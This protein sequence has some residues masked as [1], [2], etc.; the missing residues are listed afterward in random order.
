MNGKFG[1]LFLTVDHNGHLN[2]WDSSA[3]AMSKR[4]PDEI[5]LELSLTTDQIRMVL[6]AQASARERKQGPRSE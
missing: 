6:R 3:Q 2:L 4:K 5:C 1:I